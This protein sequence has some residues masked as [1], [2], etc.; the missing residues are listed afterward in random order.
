LLALRDAIESKI[1]AVMANEVANATASAPAFEPTVAQVA[2]PAL[3][4]SITS[5]SMATTAIPNRQAN[6]FTV[7]EP[8]ADND[9]NISSTS[10]AQNDIKK[11]VTAPESVKASTTTRPKSFA[12]SKLVKSKWADEPPPQPA[13]LTYTPSD[14]AVESEEATQPARST[15]FTSNKMVESKWA[16]EPP[17][18]PAARS[19][20]RPRSP[21]FGDGKVLGVQAPKYEPPRP[22][23]KPD[24]KRKYH[25]PGPG[26][27]QLLKDLKISDGDKK[28]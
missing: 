28:N 20:V 4:S 16:N 2:Q 14:L 23:Q 24:T 27:H 1:N 26:F 17:S 7:R 19:I 13:R 6:P 11:D 3:A 15:L 25:A 5:S 21:I 9:A 18:R 10:A 22:P 8:L 12:S